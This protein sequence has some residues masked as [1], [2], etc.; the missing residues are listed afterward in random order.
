MSFIF[1]NQ[2]TRTIAGVYCRNGI[3]LVYYPQVVVNV[4]L[5]VRHYENIIIIIIVDI[6]NTALGTYD[7]KLLLCRYWSLCMCDIIMLYGSKTHNNIAQGNVIII[8]TYVMLLVGRVDHISVHN[9]V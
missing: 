9:N 2:S 3:T 5:P 7:Y 6:W 8:I 1:P 4:M